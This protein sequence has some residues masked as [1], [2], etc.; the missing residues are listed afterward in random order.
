M[1]KGH[2]DTADEMMDPASMMIDESAGEMQPMDAR[3]SLLAEIRT[4]GPD[5]IM[6]ELPE[7]YACIADAVNA[8]RIA[9][10]SE[11]GFLLGVGD[12]Y[13]AGV[14]RTYGKAA[15]QPQLHLPFVIPF[16]RTKAA[17]VAALT[18]YVLRAR[19]A[20]DAKRAGPAEQALAKMK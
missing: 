7:V 20:G 19:G 10:L 2:G 16:G 13:A 5:R 12:P 14:L 1:A 15:K 4:W 6:T 9:N 3:E 11:K 8:G 17:T 18:D